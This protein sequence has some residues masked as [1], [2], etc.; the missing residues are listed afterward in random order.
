[1]GGWDGFRHDIIGEF[2][3][4]RAMKLAETY[5]ILKK[6]T[7]APNGWNKNLGGGL[8]ELFG[9]EWRSPGREWVMENRE[10]LMELL[11]DEIWKAEKEVENW[12]MEF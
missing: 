8:T 2:R 10:W 1:M 6:D 11:V 5:W 4:E 7:L 12:E 3:T 9:K